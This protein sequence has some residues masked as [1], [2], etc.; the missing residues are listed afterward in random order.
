M[1]GRCLNWWKAPPSTNS[2]QPVLFVQQLLGLPRPQP[3][4][5]QYSRVGDD[6]RGSRWVRKVEVCLPYFSLAI[7]HHLSNQFP[8]YT[9]VCIPSQLIIVFKKTPDRPPEVHIPPTKFYCDTMS[10][11]KQIH[12]AKVCS[13]ATLKTIASLYFIFAILRPTE[14]RPARQIIHRTLQT[15]S[16]IHENSDTGNR[17][18]FQVLLLFYEGRVEGLCVF[19]RI[20]HDNIF[21]CGNFPKQGLP[22][23]CLRNMN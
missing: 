15:K 3:S 13:V 7:N 21:C 1:A 9:T 17:P 16:S 14:V 12:F 19:S 5:N 4:S 22:N 23:P 20:D 11:L 2:S 6:S 10:P 8:V 18:G